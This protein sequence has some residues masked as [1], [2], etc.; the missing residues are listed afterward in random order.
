MAARKAILMS[1]CCFLVQVLSVIHCSISLLCIRRFEH[2]VLFSLFLN[3]PN[4][5]YSNKR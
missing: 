2:F 1:S 3:V 4:K 5:N